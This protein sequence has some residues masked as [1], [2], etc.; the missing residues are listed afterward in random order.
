MIAAI[1]TSIDALAAGFS[2]SILNLGIV[3]LTVTTGIITFVLSIVGVQI[4]KKFGHILENRVELISGIVLI[5]IGIKILVDH[6]I[7]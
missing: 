1:A 5:G 2:L 7:S 3:L 4:G 6:L